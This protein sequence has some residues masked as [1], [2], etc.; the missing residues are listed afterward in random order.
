MDGQETFNK[1]V[2]LI[3]STVFLLLGMCTVVVILKLQPRPG[4]VHCGRRCGLGGQGLRSR[5]RR[6]YSRAVGLT[7]SSS[8]KVDLFF[9]LADVYPDE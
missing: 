7:K 4:P 3:G 8:G 9:Q 5:P 6:N 1:K 2:A